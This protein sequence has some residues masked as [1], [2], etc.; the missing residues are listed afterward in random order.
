MMIQSILTL[1]VGLA[2]ALLLLSTTGAV[3]GFTPYVPTDGWTYYIEAARAEGWPQC[4]YRF[5][6][7]P[8]SCDSVDLWDAAGI[9]QQWTFAAVPGAASGVFYLKTSCGQ[10]LSYPG[11]C[12]SHTV[13]TWPQAGVNQ[14]FSLTA[15]PQSSGSSQYQYFITAVGRSGCSYR[16]LSFPVPCSTSGPDLV[17]LWSAPGPEQ[18]FRIYPAAASP[19][20]EVPLN[21][22][23]PCADPYAWYSSSTNDYRLVCTGG[24]LNLMTSQDLT[25]A[26]YFRSVGAALGGSP[27]QW[28]SDP[29]RWA[30]E[31]FHTGGQ[32]VIF[33]CDTQA[34][35]NAC[36]GT[37]PSDGSH[38]IGWVW[39]QSGVAPT[40]WRLYSPSYLCLGPTAGGDIDP[41]VFK[42]PASGST[43]L[44]WKSD[45]NRLGRP[46]TYIWT[47]E[48]AI[49][50]Q[51]VRQLGSPA[52]LLNSTGLWWAAV[53]TG[54]LVEGPE[55]IFH[56]GFYYLFF[57]ASTYCSPAYAEGVARSKSFHGPYEKLTLPLLST[58]LVGS[59]G[60]TKLIGPGHASY[61]QNQTTSEWYAVWHASIGNN[62]NR[63]PFISRLS[64]SSVD[65]WPYIDF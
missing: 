5:L 36:T 46:V 50:N 22:D 59:S 29:D 15:A 24:A 63:Y 13:D 26:S 12:D 48:V 45:D 32:D 56:G 7:Y 58:G 65:N 11:D 17:D 18:T 38:R 30:P 35:D 27:P 61:L 8:A 3:W 31:N 52:V 40:D 37:A 1:Q 54:S 16:Y 60:G 47:Q 4:A 55:V 57:A 33:V 25:T 39:S 28:A 43:Y 21:A 23:S 6:S 49:Q 10:Y 44:V 64:F 51:T 34:T 53:P 41:H 19:E 2:I 42:D 62:C 9:N 14:Q 20:A